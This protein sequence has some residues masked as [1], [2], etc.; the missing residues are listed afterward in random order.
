MLHVIN[1]KSSNKFGPKFKRAMAPTSLRELLSF[2]FLS[3]REL[4]G[5]S[6]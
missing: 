3:L 5:K 4:V 1:L 2:S 6:W